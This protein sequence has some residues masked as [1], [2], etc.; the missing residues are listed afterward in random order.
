MAKGLDEASTCAVCIGGKTPRGWFQQEIERALDLQTR[1]SDFRV[2][3]V[4]LPD[5][6]PEYVP[7][8]L[9][10]RTWADFRNDED[11]EYAFQVLKQGI[12]GEPVGRWQSEPHETSDK[13]FAKYEKRL[14]ELGKFRALGVHEEVVIEYERK[15]LDK[16]LDEEGDE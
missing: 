14:V 8:F 11:P 13:Y 3:P 10:L 12:K 1:D 15:I 9:T 7:A 2:I 5:A 6:N 4:L 16:W